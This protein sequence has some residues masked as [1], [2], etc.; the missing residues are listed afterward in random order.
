MHGCS[1]TRQVCTPCRPFSI[2]APLNSRTAQGLHEGQAA[3]SDLGALFFGTEEKS[4]K[5]EESDEEEEKPSRAERTPT[6]H[7]QRMPV[8]PGMDPAVLKVPRVTPRLCSTS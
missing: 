8:F 1:R 4:P 6:S 7:P 5:R 2:D 3:A